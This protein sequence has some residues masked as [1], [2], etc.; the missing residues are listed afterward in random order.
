[1]IGINY[2][3]SS[4]AFVF[5]IFFVFII[6]KISIYLCFTIFIAF[7]AY[8]L[9]STKKITEKFTPSLTLGTELTSFHNKN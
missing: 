1:M 7:F 6:N 8:S 9:N 4:F 5:G 2:F 3:V